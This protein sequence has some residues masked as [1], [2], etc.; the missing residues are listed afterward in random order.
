MI[1]AIGFNDKTELPGG[2]RHSEALHVIERFYRVDAD[3]LEWEAPIEG[4]NVF[5]KPWALKKSF[6]LRPELDIVDEFVP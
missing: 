3:N 2:Y 6:P 5:G 4:P 1:D